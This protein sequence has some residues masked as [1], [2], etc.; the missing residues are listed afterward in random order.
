MVKNE[1]KIIL[2]MLESVYK[3]IDYW[4]IQDNGSTDGTQKII[5]DFF[6]DK[7][8]SFSKK[9]YLLSAELTIIL[10]FFINLKYRNIFYYT[11]F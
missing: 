6:R 3:Y 2:R 1:S 8:S 9:K 5:E 7:N 11:I 4:V 10:S